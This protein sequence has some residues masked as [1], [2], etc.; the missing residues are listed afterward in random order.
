MT[1]PKIKQ[2]SLKSLVT[3][4]QQILMMTSDKRSYHKYHQLENSIFRWI[5]KSLLLNQTTQCES[6]PGL[7]LS[8]YLFGQFN[9]IYKTNSI[10]SKTTL[11]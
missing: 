3:T 1:I 2:L 7:T 4:I 5:A 8:A 9:K 11:T 10:Y 6:S